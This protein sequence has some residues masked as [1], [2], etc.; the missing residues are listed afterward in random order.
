MQMAVNLLLQMMLVVLFIKEASA[1]Y[2]PVAMPGCEESCGSL[3]IPYPFG[4]G[5][6]CTKYPTMAVS[7]NNSINPPK[8]FIHDRFHNNLEVL[9]ISLEAGT[10]SIKYPITTD[11]TNRSHQNPFPSGL[12]LAAYYTYSHTGN[13]FIAMGCDN[14][15]L[16]SSYYRDDGNVDVGGCVSRCI[17]SL[18]KDNTCFGINCCQAQ[19]LPSLS[20]VRPSVSNLSSPGCS[21]GPRYVVPRMC[22][23]A[24]CL[25]SPNKLSI[26]LTTSITKIFNIINS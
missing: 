21:Q 3:I 20:V 14:L 4:I 16:L 13:L 19:F 2:R 24:T 9:N 12:I 17:P 26:T 1:Q 25:N 8:A 18:K 11:C 7:C 22:A 10:I 5:E 23:S 15:A 6:N